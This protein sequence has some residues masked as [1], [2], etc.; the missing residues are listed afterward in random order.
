MVEHEQ[1][2]WDLRRECAGSRV[3][4]D[5]LF[6]SG[7]KCHC[8]CAASLRSTF[9]LARCATLWNLTE[10]IEDAFDSNWESWLDEAAGWKPFFEV[11]ARIRSSDLVTTL[12]QLDLVTREEVDALNQLKCLADG[13]AV[14]IPDLFDGQRG[15]VSLLA[16]G[17]GLGRVGEPVIP[18]ARRL[19][20]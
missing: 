2:A 11:I 5:A 10:E 17:F 4:S 9:R 19:D 18:Y 3:P 16:L 20:A 13:H 6:C 14:Q 15:V 7:S 8:R 1:A 12:E